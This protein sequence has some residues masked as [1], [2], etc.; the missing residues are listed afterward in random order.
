MR[1][2]WNDL[3]IIAI[4]QMA[5]Q[6]LLEASIPTPVDGVVPEWL[7]NQLSGPKPQENVQPTANTFH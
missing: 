1:D 7:A 5:N 3:M 4:Q 6:W 2:P